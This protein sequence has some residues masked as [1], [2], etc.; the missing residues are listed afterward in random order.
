M[1]KLF[2]ILAMV[3]LYITIAFGQAVDIPITVTDNVGNSQ[4]INFGL[5]LTA[6]DDIDPAL[7]E[8]DLPPPPPGN[9]FDARWWLPPFAGAL[10]SW[11][12]YRAPGAP[13]A[14]PFTGQ[15]EY[16]IK[17]QSTDYPITVEWNLPPEI[18]S[19]SVIQDLF[20][21]VL[22][23]A[24]FSGTGS[25]TVT[26]S[27]IGGLQ[28][29]VDYDNAGPSGPAPEFTIAPASLDFGSVAVGSS[30]TLQAT[31]SNPG[32]DD[33]VISNLTSSDGQFTFAPNTFPITVTPGN[34][35]IFDVT[36]TPSASGLQTATLTFTHNAPGSPTSYSVQGT[37][38]DPGPTFSVSPTS[39]NFGSVP[40]GS[41]TDL[42]VT[43]T[44]TGTTNPLTIS[45][46]AIAATEFSVSPTSAT[47][48]AGG[49][50]V[51]TVTF[52]PPSD[53]S[54]TGTL[55]FT[56]DAPGSPHNVPLSGTGVSTSGL[57]FSPDTVYQLEDDS[58][59]ETMQLRNLQG[60]KAQAI[61]F[62][63]QVNKEVDDNVILT[64][65]NIQKGSDVSDPSWV[66]NYNIVR[67]AITGNGASQDEIY[68][69]LYN[70]NQ[71]GGLDPG[72]YNNLF[73]VQYR[74]ADL[75]ALQDSVKSS[76]QITNAEAS[77]YD[78]FPLDITPSVDD[79]TVIAE[80]RV[81]SLGD[82]NGDGC[83]DILDLIMVVDHIIGKDSLTGD[84]FTRADIAPWSPGASEPNPDG[85][86]NVQGSCSDSEYHSY[87]N[88][89]KWCSSKWLQLF[90]NA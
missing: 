48:P 36:F 17:F 62:R 2:S 81:S 22:V 18:A 20:G 29:L 28:V 60:G 88:V 87:R 51:F 30:S 63:L 7:G 1:R 26:S 45:S 83:L 57:I 78:G 13:P 23:S 31:V 8:S 50:Q 80:N 5:D 11:K 40:V 54:Y 67:G 12:D 34:D 70:L 72:S 33:L 27:A 71:D 75:P 4:I 56:D 84:Y 46:A 21:G 68:V 73:T 55:V 10:S 47:I 58:Y 85:I 90:G 53:G 25:V 61:Q 41:P 59:T 52:D 14:F 69:L 82:V 16:Q 79:L 44:N 6:T 49:N 35:Q 77:T 19:T 43:V 74:I 24:N 37:G 86:V 65:Q 66:L 89:S 32:T 9:A 64:F 15:V 38:T 42:S 3:L 76:V 39:L